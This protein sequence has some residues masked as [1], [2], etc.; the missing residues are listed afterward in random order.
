MLT[1]YLACDNMYLDKSDHNFWRRLR[2]NDV[3]VVQGFSAAVYAVELVD[4][5][6]SFRFKN[7][8]VGSGH[9]EGFA[10]ITVE[11]LPIYL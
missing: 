5:A 8:D 1:D 6:D 10:T 3:E 9:N 7:A 4:S 11:A 2:S